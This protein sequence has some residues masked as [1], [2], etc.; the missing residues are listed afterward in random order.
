MRKQAKHLVRT[1]SVVHRLKIM[2]MKVVLFLLAGNCLYWFADV[3][4]SAS[5]LAVFLLFVVMGGWRF[6]KVIIVTLPRDLR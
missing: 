3:S 6:L 2:S 5:L 1:W 4:L